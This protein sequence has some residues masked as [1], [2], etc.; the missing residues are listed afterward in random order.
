MKSD[1]AYENQIRDFLSRNLLFSDGTFPY[2]D[3][4][5]LLEEGI[6]DSMGVMEVVMFVQSNFGI[7][8]DANEIT[9]SNFDSVGKLA[10]Y[11]RGKTGTGNGARRASAGISRE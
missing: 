2:E 5:S 8:V 3:E 1:S 7:A 9:R 11:I 10:A 4:T 6:V